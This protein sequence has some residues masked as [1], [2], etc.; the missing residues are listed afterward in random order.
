M[1]SRKANKYLTYTIKTGTTIIEASLQLKY[2]TVTLT[3]NAFL[4]G[5][6]I[7]FTIF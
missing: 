6:T 3:D 1:F 2:K 5:E 4:Y 7:T